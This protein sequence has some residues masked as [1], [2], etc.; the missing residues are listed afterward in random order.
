MTKKSKNYYGQNSKQK[1]EH[2]EYVNQYYSGKRKPQNAKTGDILIVLFMLLSLN[3]A[4]AVYVIE[5]N[6]ATNKMIS[7]LNDEVSLHD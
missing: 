2:M 3:V 6:T 7:E 4:G 5:C 1:G